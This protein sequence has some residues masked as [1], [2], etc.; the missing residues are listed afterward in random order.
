VADGTASGL[1]VP[2]PDTVR[3]LTPRQLN[4]ACHAA[5]EAA[6]IDKRICLH[7][8]RHSFATI[9]SSKKVDIRVIRVLLGHQK[10]DTTAL[11]SRPATRTIRAVR[12][13]LE[14]LAQ[15]P[16]NMTVKPPA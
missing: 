15:L 2:G 9:S 16:S 14:Q 4:R 10:L 6:G 1:A 8:L 13:P 7:T 5:A 12:S 11:C 3:P